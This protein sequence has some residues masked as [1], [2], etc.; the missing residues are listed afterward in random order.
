MLVAP[1]GNQHADSPDRSPVS[2]V[3]VVVTVVS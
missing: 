1:L 3:L 2:S